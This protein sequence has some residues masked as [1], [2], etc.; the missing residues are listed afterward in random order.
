MTRGSPTS[1]FAALLLLAATI[2]AAYW[3]VGWRLQAAYQEALA[4]IGDRRLVLA[5]MAV[6]KTHDN[7]LAVT[8]RT[9]EET[10]GDSAIAAETD[11]S[12][13]ALLQ[14]H[15]QKLL[16]TNAAQLPSV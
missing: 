3:L 2:L 4:N 16:E 12:A 10:A 14:S 1:R 9:H 6:A 7:A 11:S 15:L 5:R 13:A 8:L